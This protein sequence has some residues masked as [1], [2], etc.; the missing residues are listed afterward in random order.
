[1]WDSPS[2]TGARGALPLGSGECSASVWVEP[3]GD[4]LIY[5]TK[6]DSFDELS[7]RDKLA[8]IRVRLEPRL[9][10]ATNFTQRL[11][12]RNASV[13]V[14]AREQGVV[15]EL[16]VDANTAALRL[17]ARGQR[18][19]A[20]AAN[21]EIW[22]TGPARGQGYFCPRHGGAV[23]N[24]TGDV[25][26]A[27]VDV[28]GAEAVAVAHVNADD[29]SDALVKDT[30]QRQGIDMAGKPIYN[31]MR[32]RTFG[33]WLSGSSSSGMMIRTNATTLSSALPALEHSLVVSM[34]TTVGTSA[35]L[36]QWVQ[37][38]TVLAK[39]NEATPFH[40]AA[41]AQSKE[42]SACCAPL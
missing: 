32:G 20:M 38:A 15:V 14:E 39:S 3:N 23:W 34:L 18:R 26:L 28:L 40:V 7:S 12:L 6:S 8:R 33:V 29:V 31:P 36:R 25:L 42:A 24:R 16:F 1:V 9:Q 19:F 11:F 37:A 17:R 22:R 41:I 27:A 13:A 30:L 4:V 2:T 21:L 5:T 10:T 35:S